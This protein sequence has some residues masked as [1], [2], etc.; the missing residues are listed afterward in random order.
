MRSGSTRRVVALTSVLAALIVTLVASGESGR[1]PH[2]STSSN[3]AAQPATSTSRMP[4]SVTSPLLTEG[5]ATAADTLRL[6]GQVV[7][8]RKRPIGGASVTLGGDRTVLTEADGGFAFDGLFEGA[9]SVIAEAGDAYA[10]SIEVRLDATS[11]P[12]EL[13]LTRGPSL[14]V[15]VVDLDGAPIAGAR[16]RTSTRDTRTDADGNAQLRAVDYDSESFTVT[17]AAFAPA[18]VR[19]DTGDDPT[20]TIEQEVVLRAGTQL[21]GIVLDESG[22]PVANASVDLLEGGDG[23]RSERVSSDEHGEFTFEG[24]ARG[25]YFITARSSELATGPGVEVAIDGTTPART[26]VYAVRGAEVT[27]I[28]VDEHDRPIAGADVRVGWRTTESATDGTFVMRGL[29]AGELEIGARSPTHGARTSVHHIEARG[30]LR[31]RLV[32]DASTIAGVVVDP[33][34]RP[35]EGASVFARSSDPHGFGLAETDASGRFDLGG[36]PPGEYDVSASRADS[37]HVGSSLHISTGDRRVRLVVDERAGLTGT[38][39]L[40]G[41]PVTYYGYELLAPGDDQPWQPRAVRELTGAFT[42]DDVQPGTWTVAIVGPG[43]VTKLVRGVRV[44]GGS[45]TDLG[46]IHVVHGRALRGRIVDARGAPVADAEVSV[47]ADLYGD[48]GRGGTLSTLAR[49]GFVTRSGADGTYRIDGVGTLGDTARLVVTH[50]SRG[51]AE[52]AIKGR[53]VVNVALDMP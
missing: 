46:A 2:G 32:L 36:L 5:G 45:V 15:R 27:G 31:V 28:V 24:I 44:I 42:D 23:N 26:V 41:A 49:G 1:V 34:G 17:A 25:D 22:Q 43:F 4:A 11:D 14:R 52:A 18:T 21:A 48:S 10:E 35:V 20:A 33:A 12:L 19:V 3:A 29:E 50:P 8:R 53:N 39:V 47:S 30:Q 37:Q 38:V 40:D 51:T 9:Y 7:D 6:E 13:E 16:V